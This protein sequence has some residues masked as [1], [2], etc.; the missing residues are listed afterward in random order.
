M[1]MRKSTSFAVFVLFLGGCVSNP[2]TLLPAGPTSVGAL[3]IDAEGDWNQLKQA[4]DATTPTAV[5]TLD[6]PMLDRIVVFGGVANGDTL[7]KE[8]KKSEALP[9]FHDS[10]LP[11][12]L[13]K[14]IESYLLK[15]FGE[16]QALVESNNIRPQRYGSDAGVAFEVTITPAE[17]ATYK[18]SV[19][20]FIAKQ[21]LYVIMYIAAEP[22]YYGK[23]RAVAERMIGSAKL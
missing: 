15:M 20:A 7:V 9:H 14:F 23:Y 21:K 16:G 10:M 13:V 6:G 5:W 2:Y 17:L 1:K 11:N 8:D 4:A 18:G 19:G 12:E 3:R 22:Y